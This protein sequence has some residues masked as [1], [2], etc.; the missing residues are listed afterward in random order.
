[1]S[2][3]ETRTP[4]RKDRV[5]EQPPA[6]LLSFA[7]LHHRNSWLSSVIDRNKGIAADCALHTTS[8]ERE[9][10]RDRSIASAIGSSSRTRIFEEAF[11]PN[12]QSR[13]RSL[14]RRCARVRFPIPL[15]S[16]LRVVSCTRGTRIEGAR[17][18]TTV[19]D[20]NANP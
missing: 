4:T 15:Q 12:N 11:V 7:H 20:T 17:N 13:S 9:R 10:E 1:V 14:P 2:K 5:A 18:R 16:T 8:I 19:L 3:E 6:P